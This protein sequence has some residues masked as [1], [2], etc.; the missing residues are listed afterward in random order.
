MREEKKIKFRLQTIRTEDTRRMRTRGMKS[1][2][3][4]KKINKTE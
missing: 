4:N 2:K 1:R 3:R